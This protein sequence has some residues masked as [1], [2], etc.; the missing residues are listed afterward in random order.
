MRQGAR[1]RADSS[2][3]GSVPEQRAVVIA[4]QR[5][6]R[7]LVRDRVRLGSGADLVPGEV[8]VQRLAAGVDVLDEGRGDNGGSPE[9]P[10]PGANDAVPAVGLLHLAGRAVARLDLEALEIEPMPRGIPVRPQ[11]SCA[12]RH[13]ATSSMVGAGMCVTRG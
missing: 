10:G 1:K 2:N 4:E 13:A 6:Q 9:D 11:L 7:I 3:R 12:M 8:D 5:A